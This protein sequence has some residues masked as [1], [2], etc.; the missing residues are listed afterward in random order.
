MLQ[1]TQKEQKKDLVVQ[2]DKI[3]CTSCDGIGYHVA[4]HAEGR[5]CYTCN[6]TG[7]IIKKHKQKS[8]FM[9]K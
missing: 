1:M 5:L 8:N 6:G 7:K 9:G 2:A 4:A 3:L